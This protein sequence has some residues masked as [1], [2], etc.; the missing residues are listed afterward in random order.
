[1][2]GVINVVTKT[3]NKTTAVI[4]YEHGWYENGKGAGY[5]SNLYLQGAEK[6]YTYKINAGLNNSRPYDTLNPWHD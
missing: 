3:P 6:N 4:N 5:K 1:M 2:G